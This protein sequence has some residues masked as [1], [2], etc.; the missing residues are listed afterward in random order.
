MILSRG[1]EKE[2]LTFELDGFEYYFIF[3]GL[4][5]LINEHEEQLFSLRE[6]GEG[7]YDEKRLMSELD[8]IKNLRERFKLFK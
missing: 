8:I 3:R 1:F 6:F 4:Q 7:L 5:L 2:K